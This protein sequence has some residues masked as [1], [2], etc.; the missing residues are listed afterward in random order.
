M[1]KQ[2]YLGIDSGGTKTE[3]VLLDGEG[4]IVA[5]A[6][7]G[8]SAIIGKPSPEA[9]GVIKSL[10]DKIFLQAGKDC[11]QIEYC[12]LGLNGIDFEDEYEMQY[13][14]FLRGLNLEPENFALVNDGIPALWGAS[15]SPRCAILQHGTG[16]TSAFRPAYGSER[17]FDHLNVC[18][19][20]DIR[21]EI[22]KLAARMNAG[23]VEATPFLDAVL[24]QLGL[25]SEQF[26][27]YYYKNKYAGRCKAK[28]LMDIVFSLW[29]NGDTGAGSLMEK[30]IDDYALLLLTMI[31]K[32]GTEGA[33]AVIGGG[34]VNSAPERLRDEIARR[35][36]AVCPGVKMQSPDFS[37]AV[38]AAVM[39]AFRSGADPAGLYKNIKVKINEKN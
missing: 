18:E 30:A 33:V 19:C 25:S 35:I 1:G 12:V 2:Y 38:G 14:E 20:F 36:E 34:V 31:K 32:A 29:Q 39:A 23:A 3:A 6:R 15:P 8:A 7:G 10:M 22:L 21:D 17:L 5:S 4:G 16:F 37:P 9:M 24:G 11:S 28:F 13:G 27:E 26:P